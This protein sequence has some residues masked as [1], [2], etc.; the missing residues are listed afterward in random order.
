MHRNP[1][2]HVA[3]IPVPRRARTPVRAALLT[4]NLPYSCHLTIKVPPT[5]IAR[6][7]ATKQSRLILTLFFAMF[8]WIASLRSQLR[9][10]HPRRARTP[11]APS[12]HRPTCRIPALLRR[13]GCPAQAG[14]EEG[15]AP[16]SGLCPA[17]VK[18]PV[19][20]TRRSANPGQT[21]IP[22]P[23][24]TPPLLPPSRRGDLGSPALLA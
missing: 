9:Q 1:T 23:Y 2:H 5:V 10:G 3:H 4:P 19:W 15:S 12:H 14:R 6:S 13:G 18:C 11:Y 21:A 16:D 20:Y 24:R 8:F 22:L 7:N 17:W